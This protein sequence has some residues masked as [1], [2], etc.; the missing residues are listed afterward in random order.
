MADHWKS[1][2]DLLGA[3]GMDPLPEKQEKKPVASGE[4]A[5]EATPQQEDELGDDTPTVIETEQQD[6]S[7]VASDSVAEAETPKDEAELAADEDAQ[8]AED[9]AANSESEDADPDSAL[10]F[11]RF[12]T[13]DLAPAVEADEPADASD[14]P[15]VI[16]ALAPAR[17]MA[18]KPSA[19]EEK[20]AKKPKKKSSWEKLANMFSLGGSSEPEVEEADDTVAEAIPAGSEEEAKPKLDI[21]GEEAAEQDTE[22]PALE[23]M[24][25][26]A[27]RR[28]PAEKREKRVV[29]D[30]GWD[31]D[32]PLNSRRDSDDE[33]DRGGEEPE[34]VSLSFRT[35]K[36]EPQDASSESEDEGREEARRGRRRRRGGRRR[37]RDSEA[38]SEEPL[39]ENAQA[40]LDEPSAEFEDDLSFDRDEGE[41]VERRSSRRR[42]R[43]RRISRDE[44][45]QA[46]SRR[47]EEEGRDRERVREDRGRIRDERGDGGR[48]DRE[49][50]EEQDDDL[51]REVRS[52]RRDR[53]RDRDRRNEEEDEPRRGRRGR[54][55]KRDAEE[56]SRGSSRDRDVEGRDEEDESSR[57]KHRN[58]PTWSQALEPL[59]EANTENHRRSE[60]RGGGSGRGRGRR[61]N[62]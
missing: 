44:D 10:S 12:R 46:E 27:P 52:R 21:F 24:F 56:P 55:G 22:N 41:E 43:G 45:G 15:D 54:G 5:A 61:S 35:K 37:N 34:E 57:K 62:S 59:I 17:S 9:T 19:L 25:A 33:D 4:E 42:R 7:D 3:P 29:D 23:A 30:L 1:L 60:S 40:D 50:S 6:D 13:Q 38:R 31:D 36:E 47:D 2:A 14:E 18:S 39:E 48:G 32:E 11:K 26:D 58:I 49:S 20:V 51:D 28:D 53:G 8:E 16:Q